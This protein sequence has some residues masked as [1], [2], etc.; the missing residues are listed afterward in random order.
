[1]KLINKSSFSD[2]LVRAVIR[3]VRPPGI[4]KFKVEVRDKKR[5]R[6]QRPRRAT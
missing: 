2:E 6:I 3:F 1:M 4:K 5:I